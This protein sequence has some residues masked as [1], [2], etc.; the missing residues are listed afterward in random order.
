MNNDLL[1]VP[2]I[3]WITSCIIC[4]FCSWDFCGKYIFK[5][6][7]CG[8]SEKEVSF[9]SFLIQSEWK[10]QRVEK[11]SRV[12]SCKFQDFYLEIT[13]VFSLRH[14]FC[15]FHHDF[16]FLFFSGKSS[17]GFFFNSDWWSFNLVCFCSCNFATRYN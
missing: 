6:S 13:S 9:F 14:F 2:I 8:I 5:W 16:C 4:V 11:R 10:I 12:Y 7:D 17:S 15:G 3:V 1:F